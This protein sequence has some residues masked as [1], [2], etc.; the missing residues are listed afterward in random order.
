MNNL[1]AF[2]LSIRAEMA[3]TPESSDH[4]SI[5]KR[6]KEVKATPRDKAEPFQPKT[7]FPFVGNPRE[8]MPQGLPFKLEDY[9]ELLDWTGRCIREDKRGAISSKQPPILKRLNIDT[10]NWLYS[11]QHFER[12]F[13]SLAGKLGT[14][15]SKL[16]TLGYVR[17]PSVGA[18]LT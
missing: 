15:K 10:K 18:V 7:L 16:P 5:K 11:T 1:P 17:I 4:T 8:P 14:I 2:L 13:K 9:L 6:I 3:E 12:S